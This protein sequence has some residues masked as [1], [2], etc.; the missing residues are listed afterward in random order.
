MSADTE[1]ESVD[2]RFRPVVAIELE[3]LLAVDKDPPYRFATM[4]YPR[5]SAMSRDPDAD[6]A[7]SAEGD[8]PGRGERWAWLSAEGRSWVLSLF[9]RGIEVVWWSRWHDSADGYLGRDPGLPQMPSARDPEQSGDPSA[10]EFAESPLQ[11]RATGRPLLLV[12]NLRPRM[13]EEEYIGTRRPVDR[14]ITALRTITRSD[15]RT[16]D[17]MAEMD[18]WLAL[19]RTAPGQEAL[20]RHRR[21]MLARRRRGTRRPL[22]IG[23]RLP[24]VADVDALNARFP[25]VDAWVTQL[26]DGIRAVLQERGYDLA[27]LGS[28][29]E[30]VDLFAAVIK[31]A[32]SARKTDPNRKTES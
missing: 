26:I 6:D 14:A 22:Q 17:T 11:V 15:E 1:N 9:G 5:E 16:L 8:E 18:C 31:Q 21:R 29:T 10:E 23:E 25:I 12:T 24:P 7:A 27:D 4:K 28:V 20:R 30:I 32:D 13:G 3:G 2:D 19:A